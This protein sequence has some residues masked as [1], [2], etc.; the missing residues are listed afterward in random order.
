MFRE[1]RM[2]KRLYAELSKHR[3]LLKRISGDAGDPPEAARVD[4]M[5]EDLLTLLVTRCKN[6]VRVG[7]LWFRGWLHQQISRHPEV[8]HAVTALCLD[9]QILG[10]AKDCFHFSADNDALELLNRNL[11]SEIWSEKGRLGEYA[12]LQHGANGAR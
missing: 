2:R 6:R 7:D 10:A 5:E 9:Q 12:T 4:K 11:V 8:D 3:I 1:L